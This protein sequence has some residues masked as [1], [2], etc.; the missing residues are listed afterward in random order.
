MNNKATGSILLPVKTF[1]ATSATIKQ[2]VKHSN[3]KLAI[4]GALKDTI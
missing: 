2:V 3:G 1:L 4:V